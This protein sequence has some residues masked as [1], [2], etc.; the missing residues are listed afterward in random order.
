[1]LFMKGEGYATV[2][3]TDRTLFHFDSIGA[4]GAIPKVVEFYQLR[5]NLWNLAF[6]DKQESGFDDEIISNNQDVRMVMQT[7]A[8]IAYNFL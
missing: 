1:M 7:V 4:K 3:N 5:E 8:N 6:G 2:S